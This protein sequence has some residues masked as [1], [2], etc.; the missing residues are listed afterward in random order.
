MDPGNPG[1]HINNTIGSQ[2]DLPPT[3]LD[4]LGL[5]ASKRQLSQGKSLY[6]ISSGSDRTIY[7]NSMRQYG[8]I[9]GKDMI[10]G[11]RETHR[12]NKAQ[13]VFVIGNQNSRTV[14]S[15][16]ALE[17]I[18]SP[19][20]ALFDRFQGNLLRHYSEYCKAVCEP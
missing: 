13:N 11:E 4:L 8:I 19:P 9:M 2:V 14:Y 10:C 20:I 17:D 15:E 12:A 3:I 1:Y 16:T 7:V 5:P 18:S 6:S